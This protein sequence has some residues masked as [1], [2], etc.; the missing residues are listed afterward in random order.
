[1]EQ[2]LTILCAPILLRRLF[3]VIS[4]IWGLVACP[5]LW[6]LR[7]YDLSDFCGFRGFLHSPLVHSVAL[8]LCWWQ[9]SRNENVLVILRPPIPLPIKLELVF[10]IFN[11][12]ER[13][14]T[15]KQD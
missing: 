11:H 9:D 2:V 3:D 8:T 13:V 4:G 6:H 5:L 14:W 7:D 12:V 10:T 1:M 15:G